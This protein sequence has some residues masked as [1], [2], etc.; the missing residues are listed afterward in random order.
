MGHYELQRTVMT[1]RVRLL[2]AADFVHLL[3]GLRQQALPFLVR[4]C[5][6]LREG[7][8]PSSPLEARC[9]ID[10]FTLR[11]IAETEGE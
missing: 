10:W 1:L 3:S 6:I 9:E 8:V 2:H 7:L 4:D 11:D 5:E